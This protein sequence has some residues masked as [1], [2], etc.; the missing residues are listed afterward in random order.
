MATWSA[1]VQDLTIFEVEVFKVLVLVM[2]R[3]GGL[4]LA[5]PVLGSRNFPMV[6]KIGLTGLTAML[7]TPSIA[8]LKQTLPNEAIPFAMMGA[9]EL[10]IGLMMGF[11]MTL[12]F[13]SIQVGGQIMDMQTG[14]GM[15]NVFNPAL[16]TQFPIFGF[17]LFILAVLFLLVTNGHHLMLRAI[18][19]TFDKIPLGG[20]VVRRELLWEVSRWGSAM[21]YDGLMIAAPVAAAM[22]VA[23]AVMGLV[24]RVVPQIQLFVVGFPITIALSLFIVAISIEIYLNYLDGMFARMFKD[25]AMMIHGM[26]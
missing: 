18:V 25:V 24:G 1:I 5:A 13:A 19:A 4:V 2:V 15:I 9:G 7:V 16:G 3:I 22:L 6:A 26:S 8:A 21:F 10:M 11:V 17:F 14:F 12:V 20:F 23:Y